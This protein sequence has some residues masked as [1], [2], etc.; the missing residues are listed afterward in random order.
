MKFGIWYDFRNPTPWRRPWRQLYESLLEQIV[1]ADSLGFDSV[2]LSEHHFTDEGYLPSLFPMLAALA[3]R[4]SRMRLGTAVLLAPLHH[5]LRLAED[6]A[7]IDQI[8]GGRLE[9][10]LGPGYRPEEFVSLG[11]PRNQRGARTDETIEILKAAWTG[12]P[13]THHG[14][15]FVFDDVVVNPPP[16]QQPHPP[17]WIGGSSQSSARRAA[18]FDCN[19]MPDSGAPP[20]VYDAYIQGIG[21][22]TR[23]RTPHRIGTNRVIYVCEDPEEGW[24]DVGPH[25]LYVFNRY[26]EWF[27]AAG[28]FPEWGGKLQ[29]SNDLSRELHWVGTP[30]MVTASIRALQNRVPIDTLIF[31]A[32]PP[33]I[34]IEKSSRSL[35]LFSQY[36]LPQFA[37]RQEATA[38]P[39][40]PVGES[41]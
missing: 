30:E 24:R 36:V 26:R 17:L 37:E 16:L 33:G 4:T 3:S 14:H 35:E 7:V 11:I 18:R 22:E 34:D 13:F 15:H 25:Y 10:G 8:S 2:W 40:K 5:P 28:D 1:W 23:H 20:T 41:S 6:S 29:S 19:F 38:S 31:W 21:N 27:A 39:S 32:H 12:L 9:L